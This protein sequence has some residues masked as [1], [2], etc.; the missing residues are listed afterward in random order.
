MWCHV[1]EVASAEAYNRDPDKQLKSLSEQVRNKS[2][3]YMY[4][5][6]TRLTL[7]NA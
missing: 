5:T 7:K 6:E 2:V 4:V 1:R 3:L